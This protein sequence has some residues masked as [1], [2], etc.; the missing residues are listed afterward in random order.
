MAATALPIQF[1]KLQPLSSVG[2]NP[3]LF[4]AA[5]A[6]VSSDRVYAATE[7]ENRKFELLKA[8][9]D[10]QRGL[11]ATA[12]QRSSIEEALVSVE[13][14][15]V[16]KPIEL[17]SLEGTWRLQYTS[18]P[19]V[20][21]LFQAS[22]NLPFFNVGQVFQKFESHNETDRGVVRNIVRW[23]VP[24]LL[25]DEEGATLIVSARFSVVSRRNIQLEFEEVAVESINISEEVQAVLAPA[26]LP[27]SFIN[28]QANILQYI[29]SF[30]A[31]IPISAS[32][33]RSVGG[34]YYLSFLDGDMLLGRS[35]GGGGVFVFTKS[36]PFISY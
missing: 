17:S 11:S 27:R 2:R 4:P 22:A 31:Q 16:E 30:R 12:L 29:R 5:R 9:A 33:R 26:L 21:I 7:L 32:P 8:A 19:D 6:A 3:R 10:T 25:E 23:T 20:L 24:G 35:I 1:H 14:F 34:L 28:L 13:S 18:A 36:Q 15:D